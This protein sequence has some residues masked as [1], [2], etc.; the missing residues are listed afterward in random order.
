LRVRTSKTLFVVKEKPM[1]RQRP[2]RPIPRPIFATI[3][4][5]ILLAGLAQAAKVIKP[6]WNLFKPAQDIQLG[7]EASQE[8][9]KQVEIVNDERLTSYI[10]RIG[11]RLADVAPG[12]KYPY[13]FKVVADPSINAF[14]LPGGP[15]YV[16]TGLISAA[17][18]EAQLAGVLAHEV[19]HVALRHSTNQASKAYAFQIPIAL[20]TGMLGNKGSLL[21]SLSQIGVGFGLNSLFMKYSRNAEKDADILGARMLAEAGYD[22]IEMARFFEKL[23]GG[24]GSEGGMSQFFSDHP[25]PGNRVRYVEE[26]VS[27]LPS[28]DYTKGDSAEFRG[29]K[30]RS[31]SIKPSKSKPSKKAAS[32]IT[33]SGAGKSDPSNPNFLIYES[34]GYQLSHPKSWKVYEANDGVAATIAPDDGILRDGNGTP[35][36]ARGLMAGVFEVDARG[37]KAATDQLI[38]DLRVSNPDLNPLR[39]QRRETRVSGK[40]AES[41]L[42]EGGS[43]IEG[44]REFVWLLT[45]ETPKGLFYVILV[46]PENEYSQLRE[47]YQKIVQ[48]VQFR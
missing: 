31:G 29:M 6:G 5:V 40:P 19:S 38:D 16:H 41:V 42:L 21:G 32:P 18:N 22:P 33:D 28:G 3:A 13:T 1:L 7:Q 37:L 30:A 27:E 12:E 4:G 2:Q 44:Q 48:S 14:A 8:I 25:S 23:K 26:E 43:A 39:G 34:P 36:M 46:A 24:G 9:E 45:S 47:P 10:A 15:M 20:A 11:K 17:D 35:A